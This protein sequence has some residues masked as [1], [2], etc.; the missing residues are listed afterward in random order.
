MFFLMLDEKIP[1]TMHG[2]Y[3]VQAEDTYMILVAHS[4]MNHLIELFLR[5]K[6]FRPSVLVKENSKYQS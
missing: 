5:N 2:I 1:N 4:K 3:T 6:L